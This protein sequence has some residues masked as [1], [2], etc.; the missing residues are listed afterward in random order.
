[1]KSTI[2]K[3]I[4]LIVNL[5]LTIW[6]KKRR[7]AKSLGQLNYKADFLIKTFVDARFS[8]VSF[9][10]PTSNKLHGLALGDTKISREALIKKNSI[11]QIHG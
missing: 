2:K 3:R 11:L 4:R 9:I 1:M 7:S 8:L 10:Q 5:I 6:L